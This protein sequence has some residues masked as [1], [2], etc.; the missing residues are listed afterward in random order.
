MTHEHR[1]L[2]R[3][4]ECLSFLSW[5]WPQPFISWTLF[6]AHIST[7]QQRLEEQGLERAQLSQGAPMERKSLRICMPMSKT[8]PDLFHFLTW[9]PLTILS[10]TKLLTVIHSWPTWGVQRSPSRCCVWLCPPKATY[11]RLVSSSGKMGLSKGM[12]K[13][14]LLYNKKEKPS[15]FHASIFIHS[16]PLD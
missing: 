7:A 14:I 6:P 1:C 16:L 12:G 2:H 5:E 3:A 13:E 4:L 9:I 11:P 15:L 10:H 8:I